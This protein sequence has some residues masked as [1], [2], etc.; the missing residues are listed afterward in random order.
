VTAEWT[1]AHVVGAAGPLHARRLSPPVGRT[2]EVLRVEQPA[3]VLG[4]TQPATDADDGALV[5]AG[6]ELVRRRSGGGAVLLT[7]GDSLWV[8]VVLP[9]HDPLWEED[10]GRAAH[11]LGRAWAGAFED[12]GVDAELHTGALHR[13][14]WSRWVCFA[15]LGPGE[16]RVGG[17][18]LL[19]LAQRRSREGARFQCVVHRA[20]EPGPLV[21][22]LSLGGARADAAAELST[23][24]T[25]FGG[26]WPALVD[27]L[28]ARLPA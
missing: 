9:R 27:A 19:G 6:V 20:W 23:V 11:W 15:G 7:P 26:P 17:R 3:L 4:S 2:V 5:A 14:R 1:A 16:L 25:G 18:K 22:L 13:T 12:L 24:A 21:A 10:V 8:D 28:V